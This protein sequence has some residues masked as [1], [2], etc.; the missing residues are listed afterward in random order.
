M[1]PELR[2]RNLTILSLLVSGVLLA[3]C[4][5]QAGTV[6]PPLTGPSTAAPPKNG[7]ASGGAGVVGLNPNYHGTAGGDDARVGTAIKNK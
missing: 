7:T 2:F 3:G 1:D 4:G 5:D 6:P